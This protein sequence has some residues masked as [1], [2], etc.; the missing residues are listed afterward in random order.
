MGATAGRQLRVSLTWGERLIDV[1]HF[2]EGVAVSAGSFGIEGG[3]GA[4]TLA[5]LEGGSAR[6]FAPLG[7]LLTVRSAGKPLE[8]EQ[9][10]ARSVD[11]ALMLGEQE[12]AT[13]QLGGLCFEVRCA[14]APERVV[15]E[16]PGEA[17]IRFFKLASF[18]LL[19]FAALVT[20]IRLAPEPDEAGPGF[21]RGVPEVLRYFPVARHQLPRIELPKPLEAQD[22]PRAPERFGRA[23]PARN[24]PLVRDREA[25]LLV[26][27]GSTIL[28]ALDGLNSEAEAVFGGQGLGDGVN[29]AI[30][31]IRAPGGLESTGGFGGLNRRGTGPG[32]PGGV[33]GLAWGGGPVTRG[34]GPGGAPRPGLRARAEVLPPSGPSQLSPGLPRDEIM[35][36]VKRHQSEIKFCY[37]SQ[38]SQDRE[39]AGKVAVLFV[40]DPAGAVSEAAVAESSL[41]SEA[42]EAC[43]LGAIR[44]W[45]FPQPAG[46]GTVS[47]T[48][49]WV[50]RVA[51]EG[52]PE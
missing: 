27:R 9:L 26:V 44:R 6:L 4:T 37:D 1:R 22:L 8:K 13:L 45:R 35:R 19:A 51:G 7:A 48:F 28:G 36:V 40:I 29:N 43:M 20:A 33:V 30:E 17:E 52:E 31:A 32:G 10:A 14:R 42:V 24:S 16:L 46:G 18:A 49:P 34:P 5:R 11:G 21:F 15:G 2:G 25:N 23:D 38:L 47:V 3:P 12:V 39:L 50:F 41:E